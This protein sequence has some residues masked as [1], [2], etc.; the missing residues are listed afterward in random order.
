MTIRNFETH[1]PT[2]HETAYI[3]ETALVSG[4]VEI[5]EESS[6]WPMSV[7]RGDV[8]YRP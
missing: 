8:N 6:V 5:G 3:D 4:Q 2:I 1:S 7:L